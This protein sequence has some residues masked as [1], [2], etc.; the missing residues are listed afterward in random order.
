MKQSIRIMKRVTPNLAIVLT[1]FLSAASASLASAQS[2]HDLA[3]ARELFIDGARLLEQEQWSEAADRFRQVRAVRASSEVSYNLAIAL[4]RSGELAESAT[5]LAAV[6]LDGDLEARVRNEARR[7]LDRILPRL[8]RLTVYPEGD[9]ADHA[10]FLDGEELGL[11]R[12]AQPF[13]ITAGEHRLELRRASQTIAS[14]TITLQEGQEEEVSLVITSVS[15]DAVPIDDD[16]LRTRERQRERDR[17]REREGGD[18]I[19]E[20]WPFWTSVA[21]G[22]LAVI[23]GVAIAVD[24][25][26][27]DPVRG[28]LSPDLI[29][30]TLP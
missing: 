7:L 25:A 5:L 18:N 11:D 17:Q 14:R 15:Q 2:E 12:I 30:V 20:G 16:L 4:E 9:A 3:R 24:Q 26:Q 29:E 27:V 13:A 10:V 6:V 19:F 1:A 28:D 22:V 23:T 8:A 21:V